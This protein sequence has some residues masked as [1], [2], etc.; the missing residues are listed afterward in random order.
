[1]TSKYVEVELS[2]VYSPDNL[3]RD[4]IKCISSGTNTDSDF[5]YLTGEQTA[6]MELT[7]GIE[8][9]IYRG[10]D[11]VTQDESEQ[12]YS[13]PSIIRTPLST[14]RLLPYQISEMSG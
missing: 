14:G 12:E 2:Y 4:M 10:I 7:L 9:Q 3:V 1:M 8:T 5:I 13:A 11:V 6:Q